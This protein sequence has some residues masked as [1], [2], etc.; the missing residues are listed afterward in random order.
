[1]TLVFLFTFAI[2]QM[3]GDY[4]P[5]AAAL[6][7]YIVKD[8]SK[9]GGDGRFASMDGS[10]EG[11]YFLRSGGCS[12]DGTYGLKTYDSSTPT[13]SGVVFYLSTSTKV[14][15]KTTYAG[16][17]VEASYSVYI[18]D[19]TLSQFEYMET[20]TKNNKNYT[21]DLSSATVN[22]TKNISVVPDKN[23]KNQYISTTKEDV[24]EWTL[25]SGAYFVTLSETTD[26]ETKAKICLTSVKLESASSTLTLNP[27]DGT[28]D[29]TGWTDNNNGTWSKTVTNG[30]VTLPAV[31]KE[32]YHGGWNVSGSTVTSVN[33]SENTTVS[34]V[35]AIDTYTV[36]F[37]NQDNS[38][39][40]TE[41]NVEWDKTV[42]APATDPEAVG[43]T[44]DGWDF[45]FSTHITANTNIASKWLDAGKTYR[46]ITLIYD[47]GSDN[48]SESVEDGTTFAQPA[49]PSKTGYTFLKW[50]NA[51]TEAD[52]DFSASV[53]ADITLKAIYTINKYTVNFLNK[54]VSVYATELEVPY[55][56][57][58]S[59]PATDPTAEHYT[60]AGWDFDFNTPITDNTD[61]A[62]LWTAE[63]ETLT[64]NS[65]GGSALADQNV[66]YNTVIAA[67]VSTRTNWTL[68]G[69]TLDPTAE[70]IELYDFSTPIT[71][72]LDFTAVW[73][74]N[75]ISGSVSDVVISNGTTVNTGGALNVTVWPSLSTNNGGVKFG[76]NI[77]TGTNNPT[78]YISFTIPEGY[79]AAV[80]TITLY[81]ANNV[82]IRN[83][84]DG[85]TLN[86]HVFYVSNNTAEYNK[87]L[88]P[89]TY[90]IGRGGST[91]CMTYCSLTVSEAPIMVTFKTGEA[92][93][94]AITATSGEKLGNLFLNGALPTPVI[95][96]YTFNGWKNGENDATVNDEI[97]ESM[98]IAA[99][100]TPATYNLTLSAGNGAL[101]AGA[102]KIQMGASA[103]T[104]IT[105]TTG[106]GALVGYFTTADG[107]V[108]VIEANGTLVAG[109]V[110]GFVANGKWNRASDAE[111]FAKYELPGNYVVYNGN[112]NDGGSVPE[113]NNKYEENDEVTVLG[114]TG[115][116]TKT[117]GG[118]Q[119]AF[120]G[121]NTNSDMVNG[122]L[123]AAGDKFT[124]PD[125]EVN[126]YAVWGFAI[127]YN[128]D[129][130]TIN[131]AT[132][133]TW[134]V[135]T[136]TTTSI[137]TPLPSNVTREGY[138]FDGWYTQNGAGNK[139]TSINA[140]YTGDFVGDWALKAK[141]ILTAPIGKAQS[142][143]M[144]GLV[145]SDGTS[146]EWQNYLYSHGYSF[147]TENVSLDEKKDPSE[148]KAYDNWPYQGL[149]MKKTGSYV[150]GTVEEG[151]LVV[152][153][154]GHMAAAATVT[155]GGIA[156]ANATGLDAAEP[157]GKYNYYYVASESVLRL[158]TNSNDA[159][160]LKAITI[161]AP[162]TVSFDAN[163]GED[164]ASLNGTPSIILP[165]AE[166]GTES[167]LGWFTETT[168]GEKI[169]DAGESYTPSADITLHAQWE[170]V[171]SDARLAS[172]SFSSAAGTLSPAF[173]PEVVN[174]TY[175]MP[176]GTA[177]IPQIT[178]ATSV[179]ANAQAPIIG[180]AAAAWGEAQT[181]KGVA[182]SGDK[183]TY[184]ITMLQAP[185]DGVAIISIDVPTGNGNVQ[186][187]AADNI[188]GF[189]GGTATQKLQS[190]SKK[191]GGNG[192]YIGFTLAN[193]E[194]LQA[195]DVIR[196]NVS[197]TNGAS[198]LT[199]YQDGSDANLVKDIEW[200]A[201]EGINLIPIPSEAV[202]L[203]TL[204]IYRKSSVCNPTLSEFAILRP[205]DPVMTA[206][207][208]NGR[209]G[210]IDPLDDK[211]FNV[212]IPYEADLAALTV[213]PTIVWNGAHATTPTAVVSNGGEWVLAVDEDNTYRV[214]DKDG[215]YTDY[216]ITLTRD[217]KKYT[218]SFN[219]QGG[220]TVQSEL[221][222]AGQKLAA[223]PADPTREDYLF[224]GWAEAAEGEVVD[225]TDFVINADKT[226]YAQWK[227]ENPIV[228][229]DENGDIDHD[230]FFTGMGKGTVNFGGADHNCISFGSTASTIVGAT[231]SNKFIV[232]N[233]K[234][235]QTRIKFVLY[236]TQ[237]SAKNI[238]LQKV[239]EGETTPTNVVIEV[240]SKQQFTT[241]YY[242]YNSD[243]N[244][245][246]YV[247]TENTGIKVL[248]VKVIESGTPVN[249]AGQ[250][251][252]TLNLNKGRVFAPS[253]EAVVFEGLSMKVS[254]NYKVLNSEELQTQNNLSFKVDELVTMTLVST[255]AK[256]QVS[257]DEEGSGTEYGQ[258][259]N[260]HT[261]TPGTWYIVSSTGSNIKFTN[262]SFSEPVAIY[263]RPVNPAYLGTL[264]W[265]NDAILGGATLYEFAGKNEY[266]Y[267]VFDEVEENRLEAGKP[268]IFMP[269]DGNTEIKVYNIDDAAAL[270]TDQAPVNNMYGTITGKTLVPGVDDNMYYFSSNHIWAVK[271]FVVNINIPAYYC[272]INYP[273]VLADEPA[274]P[275]APG[276]RRVTMGVNGQNVA[277]GMGEIEASETPMKVMIDGQLF[278]IR[279]EKM[280]DATGRLVK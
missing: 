3:W 91:S 240:P 94:A 130:G 195:G 261:L 47:N 255:G 79:T 49:D 109:D 196:L 231:G 97:T 55:N 132:Y 201:T 262:I 168:G 85:V 278:I 157:A 32:H 185:K 76:G 69:W 218:V 89:G 137:S 10:N 225:V 186:T 92:T 30:N 83:D 153:K 14:S 184:T 142:I 212:T 237:S 219:A 233:A 41:E 230:N 27:N 197:A 22:K 95:A 270:T 254:S 273:A 2:G 258:G 180:D 147:S 15:V 191:L 96:G 253:G 179:N 100:L 203:S 8:V 23:A 72:D 217:V 162:F 78:R 235:T 194:E 108:K 131:D 167:F 26:P 209:D 211:H 128:L 18:K 115:S 163:G 67:P 223:A 143:D 124:M 36:N 50:V 199:L 111:L 232:Y 204:Y 12:I 34:A 263:T 54:D 121:W 149:K 229:L 259:T 244:R 134:Y 171:S 205:M 38:V 141:W 28:F 140:E 228:I 189:I 120:R 86:D 152:I 175:T 74:R 145:E 176:Y 271:D 154:L 84:I 39:F 68:E 93:Y 182:E 1:M 42:S 110:E 56:T 166:K 248:Q 82:I 206:I 246:M 61:I 101:T 51:D 122:T 81:D 264:C 279:G 43:Y 135:S 267:L 165:S 99:D 57:I 17:K 198:H 213:E 80:K 66:D 188:S 114:N 210:E 144:E 24:A 216:T 133:A 126:L 183:K 37:L 35:W 159:C 257:K 136:G 60:F 187:I 249:Q 170:A 192:N 251:G 174:Y 75:T 156:Q 113:D 277:T 280:F 260:H 245:S 138:T 98:T 226:F 214:M 31:T 46:T 158:Q 103:M 241:E 25:P 125:A 250:A 272:Y 21:V 33:V 70:P 77:T 276:R 275:A 123:Y 252:Y 173:D 268:Y 139:V 11:I 193:S 238:V 40:A 190:G 117:I 265:T 7:E 242:A 71:S 20:G 127:N 118:E 269:E 62:S 116:L 4:T 9:P 155:I 104:D 177:A 220:S 150:Q 129:G 151:K 236:N 148:N 227:Y 6:K 65:N 29:V 53:T 224:L 164:V 266:N 178:A 87:T 90:Y 48:G 64:F 274:G 256:Y 59:A 5:T 16:N 169:G 73:S 247:Y 234:T 160:V 208:I 63:Q 239:A 181:I 222:V 107:D 105:A 45:D 13:A 221:V 88:V 207:T 52:Y 106:T 112:G 172:I 243:A 146:A 161:T 119:A 200:T 58:V 19:V 44:F 202:G 102:A 215:D